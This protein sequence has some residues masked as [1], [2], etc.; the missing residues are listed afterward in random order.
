MLFST[1]MR[2]LGAPEQEPR[3]P[4]YWALV[5]GFSLSEYNRDL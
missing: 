2:G 4:K 1:Q 5:K 3:N